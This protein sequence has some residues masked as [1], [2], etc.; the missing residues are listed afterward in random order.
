VSLLIQQDT[1]AAAIRRGTRNF[2]FSAAMVA[3]IIVMAI[4]V[5]QGIFRQTASLGFLTDSAQDI[6]NGQSVKIAG[7]RVGSVKSVVLKPDAM[8][9][10]AIEIDASYMRFVTH[11]AVIE[12]RRE[13]LIGSPAL[14]IIPGLDKT[15]LAADEATL[16]FSRAE[17]LTALTNSLRDKIIP[18][19]EDVKKITGNLA[20]TKM[21]VAA[22]LSKA[23]GATDSLNTLLQTGNRQTG[24]I[25]IQTTRALETVNAD[26]PDLI[27]KT[28][29]IVGHVE[30]ITSD[31]QTSVP[32]AVKNAG[33]AITDVR[34]IITGAKSVWPLKTLIPAPGPAR[35]VTDSDPHALGS[36][37][38]P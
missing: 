38:S 9:E 3:M 7:F 18:I 11:D 35:L 30:S 36:H 19:L 34:E 37:V 16:T 12:L 4:L 25:G 27:K 5:R 17:G 10:V 2:L 28:K 6:S 31:A 22:T 1:D 20:D 13:G 26:L 32:P 14:E 15:R 23:Q 8:V 21:G 29:N 24:A 33:E